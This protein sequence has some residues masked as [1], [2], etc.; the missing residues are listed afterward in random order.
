MILVLP[1][2]MKKNN[3]DDYIAK[4]AA[5]NIQDKY[6][7]HMSTAAL[8][9]VASNLRDEFEKNVGKNAFEK[10]SSLLTAIDAT[11]SIMRFIDS[12]DKALDIMDEG[13]LVNY[14]DQSAKKAYNVYIA[15]RCS[16][17]FDSASLNDLRLSAI[18]T[19]IASKKAYRIGKLAEKEGYVFFWTGPT[20]F[21]VDPNSED[22]ERL[23]NEYN[24]L[25]NSRD[26]I[27]ESFELLD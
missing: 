27:L 15:R 1:Q 13:V 5:Q 12:T 14:M 10:Y 2:L 6:S 17:S 8:S 21:R 16:D 22:F 9:Y 20:D 19:L 11:E 3:S 4:I 24:I 23:N 18:M 25:M 26:S 7:E